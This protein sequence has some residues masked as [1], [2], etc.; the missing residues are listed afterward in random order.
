MSICFAGYKDFLTSLDM[1]GP[2]E[3]SEEKLK[4][5][6]QITADRY[7][8]RAIACKN[9]VLFQA[10]EQQ[11]QGF[12]YLDGQIV[13]TQPSR[14]SVVDRIGGGDAF[15]SGILHGLLTGKTAED[16][17]RFGIGSA[18]LKHFVQGDVSPYTEKDVER[19]I[20]SPVGD[21]SR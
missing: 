15:A 6:F 20:K 12:M 17:V 3:F 11:L 14:F 7:N 10:N 19:F 21:V 1:D 5:F 18:I 4:N 13:K 8:M 9:R 2:D 16:T